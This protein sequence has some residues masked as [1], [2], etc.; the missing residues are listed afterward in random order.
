MIL[1]SNL[2]VTASL[3]LSGLVDSYY[4]ALDDAERAM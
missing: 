1:Y 3:E 2:F 4:G